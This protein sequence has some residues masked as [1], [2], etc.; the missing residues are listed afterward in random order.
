MQRVELK[1][2]DGLRFV[3]KDENKHS[4]VLDTKVEVG[5]TE[6]GFQPV[7][8]VLIGL[9]GCMA[10]DIVSI[11]NKKRTDLRNFVV[12]VEGERANEHPKRYTTILVKIKTNKEVSQSD[13]QRAMELSR[14]KYCSVFWT[15]KTP[16][17]I[18]FTFEAI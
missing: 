9:G 11:L 18:K 13:V 15:L 8:M 12:T 4:F 1:W 16:P 14:D 3:V 5:G 17:E 2:I 7:D 10:F 6:T